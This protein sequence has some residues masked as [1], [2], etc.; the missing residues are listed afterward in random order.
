VASQQPGTGRELHL[1]AHVQVKV[2]KIAP[3]W[4]EGTVVGAQ[5]SATCFAVRLNHTDAQGRQQYAFLKAV[6]ELQVD[7]RTNEGILTVGLPPATEADWETWSKT[8]VDSA[9]SRCKR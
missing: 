9:A 2:P 5:G 1:G 3:D 7:R 8:D 4:I 6:T